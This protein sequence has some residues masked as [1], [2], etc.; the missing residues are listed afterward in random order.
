MNQRDE[1]RFKR[2]VVVVVSLCVNLLLWMCI[3]AGV[4]F[5][6]HMFR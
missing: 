2:F 5:L 6:V 1:K 4:V 3:V